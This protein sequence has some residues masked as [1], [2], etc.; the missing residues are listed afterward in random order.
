MYVLFAAISSTKEGG[1]LTKSLPRINHILSSTST[2]H[3]NRPKIDPIRAPPLHLQTRVLK[4]LGGL[5]F[6]PPRARPPAGLVRGL[7]LP[8]GRARPRPA[9][10][11]RQGSS[12][13]CSACAWW[14]SP[15]SG[16][17]DSSELR[18]SPAGSWL[19]EYRRWVAAS[20][21]IS[22]GGGAPAP[23]SSQTSAAPTPSYI[24]CFFQQPRPWPSW[25]ENLPRAP[26]MGSEHG[27]VMP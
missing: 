24:L 26:R 2:I 9:T 8:R 27:A 11:A 23:P 15:A 1:K 20:L 14:G 5:L 19:G 18:A 4:F 10:P 25:R 17:T 22:H 7:Q 6:S 21:Q 3:P 13:A 12:A 16:R